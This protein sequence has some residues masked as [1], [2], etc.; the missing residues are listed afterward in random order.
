MEFGD[1]KMIR[2]C[3]SDPSNTES[4]SIRK[5][6]TLINIQYYL[7]DICATSNASIDVNFNPPADGSDNLRQHLYRC[8]GR[9]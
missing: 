6:K 8:R 1:T 9:V 2:R 5:S 4:K 7:E 3:K